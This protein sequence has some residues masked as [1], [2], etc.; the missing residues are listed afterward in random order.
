MH[1]KFIE[2]I[3]KTKRRIVAESTY[4]TETYGGLGACSYTDHINEIMME[5]NLKHLT[6]V[7][8]G[9]PIHVIKPNIA[10][11][12]NDDPFD[13]GKKRIR[14]FIPPVLVAAAFASNPI[15][16]GTNSLLAIAWYQHRYDCFLED[17]IRPQIEAIDWNALARDWEL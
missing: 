10:R 7:F 1:P 6:H 4:F 5:R 12:E 9:A 2:V 3:L 8:Y 11:T 16:D 14:A 13:P 17:T 15:R